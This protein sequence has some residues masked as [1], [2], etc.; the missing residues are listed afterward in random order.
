MQ[1]LLLGR[2]FGLSPDSLGQTYRLNV[3]DIE[4]GAKLLVLERGEWT[5]AAGA[6]GPWM[7]T[8]LTL[9]GIVRLGTGS[10]TL[11]R[12]P[13]RYL[14]TGTGDGQTDLEGSVLLD[15]GLGARLAVLAAARYTRQLGEVDAGRVPDEAG[16]IHPFTPL[17][18]GTK[19]LGDVFVAELTPR[20][21]AGRFLAVDAHYAF[22]SRADDEYSPVVEGEAPLLRGGFTEQRVGLGL[23]YSTLRGARGREPRLP[24]EVSIAHIETIAGSN[25]MVPRA[26]RDQL[27]LRLYY[28][29]RR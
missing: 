24:V 6:A 4:L 27:E 1:A 25:G 19:R 17:H 12:M 23:S 11:E 21:L 18:P 29:L 2:E 22:I 20:V 3:G 5:P 14:E 10:P 7:R 26:G 8:R 16:V 13:H 9:A 28:R 15:V